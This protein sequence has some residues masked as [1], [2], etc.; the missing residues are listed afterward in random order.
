MKRSQCEIAA[1]DNA[2]DTN[3]SDRER[4]ADRR[5]HLAR[6]EVRAGAR[7][8]ADLEPVRARV[9]RDVLV[10]R[11]ERGQAVVRGLAVPLRVLGAERV[12]LAARVRDAPGVER[13]GNTSTHGER[14]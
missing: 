14:Q 9:R 1:V 12:R 4:R 13:A 3:L 7:A 6:D 10:H 5:V 8:A 2:C 11:V